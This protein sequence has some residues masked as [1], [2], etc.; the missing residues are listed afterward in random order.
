MFVSGF[1]WS[2][3]KYRL[4]YANKERL[5]SDQ[6]QPTSSSSYL[7]STRSSAKCTCNRMLQGFRGI[8][9]ISWKY[10]KEDK[11][12]VS[13]T[14]SCMINRGSTWNEFSRTK[15]R[16]NRASKALN[17]PY[18]MTKRHMTSLLAN[19]HVTEHHVA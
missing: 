8:K 19:Q 18:H 2:L 7:Y 6:A 5:A 12:V 4:A 9:F 14:K 16:L 3:E 15:P 13:Y 11:I 10:I 17:S 1:S